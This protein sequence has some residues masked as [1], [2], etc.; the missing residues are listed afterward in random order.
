M[1]TNVQYQ[2]QPIPVV[3]QG[4]IKDAMFQKNKCTWH[5]QKDA[6][7]HHEMDQMANWCTV[8]RLTID[9]QQM[10][11]DQRADIITLL[12][13]YNLRSTLLNRLFDHNG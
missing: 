11:R 3:H 8:G 6:S 5:F 1:L 7:E 2:H 13:D 12:R 10:K 9:F 4:E